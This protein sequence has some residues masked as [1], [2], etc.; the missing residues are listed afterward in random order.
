MNKFRNINN[1]LK[2]S[3]NSA[4]IFICCQAQLFMDARDFYDKRIK[5][6]PRIG[7]VQLMDEYAKHVIEINLCTGKPS[8]FHKLTIS[9]LKEA[10]QV[11]NLMIDYV[12]S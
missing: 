1:G 5:E 9:D 2:N 10:N 7:S 6:N 8:E 4:I 12:N 11:I 3:L